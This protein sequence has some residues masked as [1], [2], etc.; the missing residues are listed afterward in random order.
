MGLDE[1]IQSVFGRSSQTGLFVLDAICSTFPLI[2]NHL[3]QMKV[4]KFNVK[5]AAARTPATARRSLRHV[6][7]AGLRPTV[8]QRQHVKKEKL[9]FKT[10]LLVNFTLSSGDKQTLSV[11][12]SGRCSLKNVEHKNK[13]NSKTKKCGRNGWD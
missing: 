7:A 13:K 3:T 9:V 5:P 6:K 12:K 10:K 1:D 4:F 2:R 8:A 11:K